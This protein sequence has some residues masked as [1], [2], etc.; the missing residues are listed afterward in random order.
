PSGGTR[1]RRPSASLWPKV[2]RLANCPRPDCKEAETSSSGDAS[3]LGAGGSLL[4]ARDGGHADADDYRPDPPGER[5]V[6]A[7]QPPRQER[8]QRVTERGER[9]HKT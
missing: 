7:D 1:R 4:G 5:D 6:F 2:S 8:V 3:R 9:E